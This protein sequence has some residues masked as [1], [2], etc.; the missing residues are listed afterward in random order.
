M[1]IILIV[2]IC[3]LSVVAQAYA[4]EKPEL[5]K[6]EKKQMRYPIKIN[7]TYWGKFA[8][9]NNLEYIHKESIK[10]MTRAHD[11]IVSSKDS[12]T[13]LD[14]NNTLEEII[15]SYPFWKGNFPLY[16]SHP[17]SGQEGY[18]KNPLNLPLTCGYLI[19]DKENF[20]WTFPNKGPCEW[21]LYEFSWWINRTGRV[22]I[23]AP[24]GFHERP[25]MKKNYNT[26]KP[27]SNET[28]VQTAHYGPEGFPVGDPYFAQGVIG[29]LEDNDFR[30]TSIEEDIEFDPKD[31]Q[32]R[33]LH[34]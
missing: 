13:E 11:F 33:Y 25:K 3:V 5:W 17:D 15:E 4:S 14:K 12:I 9:Y 23:L 18:E 6:I 16:L 31:L 8:I 30:I 20:V 1:R 21:L 28:G 22:S 29:S 27:I 24:I 7:I 32:A 34:R 2:F 19:I 10:E 26:S